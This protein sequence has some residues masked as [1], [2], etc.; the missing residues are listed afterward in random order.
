MVVK[1]S[2]TAHPIG[3]TAHAV[4]ATIDHSD[5]RGLSTAWQRF[6]A[7]LPDLISGDHWESAHV[8]RSRIPLIVRVR[9][10]ADRV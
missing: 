6:I 8:E 10:D 3:N 5:I 1:V 4:R 9:R 7:G 2:S